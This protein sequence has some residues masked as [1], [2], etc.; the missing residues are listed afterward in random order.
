MLL[1]PEGG[2]GALGNAI[3]AR[4]DAYSHDLAG[5]GMMDHLPWLPSP[6]KPGLEQN[7]DRAKGARRDMIN[8]IRAY[9]LG[10]RKAP[11]CAEQ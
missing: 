11:T 4:Q 7:R 8:T 2:L 3:H 10:R 5:K 1:Y 6:D 9:M